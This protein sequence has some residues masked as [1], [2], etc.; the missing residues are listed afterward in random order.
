M[1]ETGRTWAQLG[2]DAI[3]AVE[4]ELGFDVGTEE[5]DKPLPHET[6]STL[7]SH[8]TGSTGRI[9]PGGYPTSSSEGSHSG[10]SHQVQKAGELRIPAAH[11]ISSEVGM[12]IPFMGTH[13]IDSASNSIY[14][15]S[16]P[17]KHDVSISN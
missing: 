3:Q 10:S 4:K 7:A 1:A 9:P 16:V 8:A 17:S 11:A 15:P 2:H 13:P 6:T 12:P 14:G 5:R